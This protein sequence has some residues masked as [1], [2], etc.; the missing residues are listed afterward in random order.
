MMQIKCQWCGQRY[1]MNRE[2]LEAAVAAA[3]EKKSIHHV[4]NCP[5]CRRALKI[6]ISE[7]KR[8][9]PRPAPRSETPTPPTTTGSE[10]K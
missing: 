9:L 4:E 7:M 10:E 8:H 3:A 5:H 1:T 2:T 6:Q